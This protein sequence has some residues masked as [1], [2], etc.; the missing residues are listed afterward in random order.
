MAPIAEISMETVKPLLGECLHRARSSA[1]ADLYPLQWEGRAALLKDFSARPLWIRIIWSRVIGAREF[2]ALR[3]LKGTE[4][5]PQLFARVG[6]DALLMEHLDARRLPK[7]REKPPSVEFFARLDRLMD[8]LHERGIGH[9]DI[10]RLNILIDD[11][12][13]PYLIDF[14]TAVACRP[15]FGGVLKRFL[16]RRYKKIDRF[17]LARIKSE[18][19]PEAM[20]DADR[21]ILASQPW[22]LKV[23]RFLKKNVY[24]LKKKR[25][26]KRL[27]KKI[28]KPFSQ[29]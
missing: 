28:T 15:G 27:M 14:A 24:R 7:N 17:N 9:G 18:L 21:E 13:R 16:F 19:L 4:G 11:K 20:T 23:G 6:P 1:Q 2:R 26:R 22:Y 5:I 25:H 29:D 12:E 8:A 3:R 10:R